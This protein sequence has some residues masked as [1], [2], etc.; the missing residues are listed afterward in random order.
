MSHAITPVVCEAVFA[1]WRR[2]HGPIRVTW[3][4]SPSGARSRPSTRQVWIA[5]FTL[6][7]PE[8]RLAEAAHELAHVILGPCPKRPPHERHVNRRS[9][10]RVTCDCVA[11]E[12]DTT[13]EAARLVRSAGLEWSRPMHTTTAVGLRSYYQHIPAPRAAV[14]AARRLA[15]DTTFAARAQ[16][17]LD[18]ELKIAEIQQIAGTWR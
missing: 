9:M 15:S 11:C 14:T 4:S 13:C 2:Q 10:H 5:P 1:G 3:I 17:R 6:G 16:A 7:D 8:M 18:R 12:T